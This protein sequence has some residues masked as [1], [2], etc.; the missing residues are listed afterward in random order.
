MLHFK[1]ELSRHVVKLQELSNSGNPHAQKRLKNVRTKLAQLDKIVPYLGKYVS[2]NRQAEMQTIAVLRESCTMELQKVSQGGIGKVDSSSSLSGFRPSDFSLPDSDIS[3]PSSYTDGSQPSM[4]EDVQ[5]TVVENPYA[6]LSEVKKEAASNTVKK[7]SNYAELDFQRIHGSEN[8]RPPSV[9]YS[10]IRINA[11]GIGRLSPNEIAVTTQASSSNAS[12]L[13][14]AIQNQAFVSTPVESFPSKEALFSSSPASSQSPV[15]EHS[16]FDEISNKSPLPSDLLEDEVLGTSPPLLLLDTTITPENVS[17]LTKASESVTKPFNSAGIKNFE[18]VSSTIDQMPSTISNSSTL[19]YP[20]G[21]STTTSEQN[22]SPPVP[23]PRIDSIF[24]E[25]SR[26][27]SP[28]EVAKKPNIKQSPIHNPP[29]Q[30]NVLQEKDSVHLQGHGN[31]NSEHETVSPSVL[32]NLQG[33]PS[34][35]DRIKVCI[36]FSNSPN[37]T[38]ALYLRTRSLLQT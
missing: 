18:T 14:S 27:K 25:R 37:K 38:L 8:L 29:G 22:L 6:S 5:Q 1:K 34:V 21:S 36:F 7:H 3:V 13:N 23:P 33:M 10:E 15:L 32:S 24:T 4:S 31:L 35:L 12:P 19:V 9:K 28:P 11:L 30:T 20:E 2:V 26:T 16:E 17:L